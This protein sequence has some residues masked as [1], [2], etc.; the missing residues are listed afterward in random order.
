[1]AIFDGFFGNALSG[2]LNPK[3]NLSDWRHASRLFVEDKMKYAPKTK[4]LY[5]VQ[6]FLS[7]P[8][9]SFIPG[10]DKFQNKIGGLVYQA[11]LPSYSAAVETRNK[12]NRKKNFQT[13]IEYQPISIVFYDDNFGVTTK[14]L[15]SYYKYYF[16]DSFQELDSGAYGDTHGRK[17]L[18]LGGFLGTNPF[19]SSAIP[20]NSEQQKEGKTLIGDTL[21]TQGGNNYRFGMDNFNSPIPF[22]SKIEISQLSRK[23]YNTFTLVRPILT[24]WDHDNV[25]NKDGA[26][27]MSNSITVRYESVLYTQGEVEVGNNGNPAGFGDPAHYDSTPS[28]LTTLGGGAQGISGILG[29]AG[30]ILDGEFG[31]DDIVRGANIVNSAQNLTTEGVIEEGLNAVTGLLGNIGNED[32]GGLP[33]TYFPKKKGRGGDEDLTSASNTNLG[34]PESDTPN[35]PISSPTVQA[36][37]ATPPP[38]IPPG[39]DLEPL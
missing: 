16:A 20:V 29:G 27:A 37:G 9:K 8:A 10:L 33:N 23:T 2:A 34:G 19:A 24:E 36:F 31:V 17:D 13:S 4:F 18:D 11:D 1:M 35:S 22:F 7:E 39:E 6:F 25:D 26:T 30:E 15:E 38:T 28:S 5:H 21:Y 3:G 14:L 12:Y 32:L